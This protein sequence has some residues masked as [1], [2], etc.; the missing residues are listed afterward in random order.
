M[1]SLYVALLLFGGILL[2]ASVF[3]GGDDGAPELEAGGG[4]LELGSADVDLDAG[5]GSEVGHSTE[6]ELAGSE[7]LLWPLKTVRFWTFFTAFGGLTGLVLELLAV[8]AQITAAIA[9]AMGLG[10]GATASW[11]FRKLAQLGSGQASDGDDF[12]GKSAE[13]LVPLRPGR[14]G[15]VRVQVRGQSVD[16]LALYDGQETLTSKDEVIIIEMQGSRAKVAR[17]DAT[18]KL[19]P[20]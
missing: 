6:L 2:G 7:G 3:F 1:L 9:G 4:D 14:P 13:I 11:T 16:L 5:S 15:K 18:D 8:P 10:V 19:T 17:L 12:L 20:V